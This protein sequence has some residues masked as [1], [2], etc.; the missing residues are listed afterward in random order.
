M[1]NLNISYTPST[2]SEIETD[3]LV[4]RNII[5]HVYTIIPGTQYIV[6]VIE[7]NCVGKNASVKLCYGVPPR[8]YPV[9]DS[10]RFMSLT[11]FM[12]CVHKMLKGHQKDTHCFK[13]FFLCERRCFNDPHFTRI[14]KF[15]TQIR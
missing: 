1:I 12:Q 7:L 10:L 11:I 13:R 3:N 5:T 14:G 6:F 2:I 15:S 8:D 9:Y 4:D